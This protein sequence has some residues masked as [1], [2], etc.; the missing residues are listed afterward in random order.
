MVIWSKR[1]IGKSG[2]SCRIIRQMHRILP[3]MTASTGRPQSIASGK[4]FFGIGQLVFKTSVLASR[5]RA[6]RAG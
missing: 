5:S 3:H 1:G 6:R 4:I 2:E